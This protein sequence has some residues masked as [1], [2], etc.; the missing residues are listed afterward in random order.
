MAYQRIFHPQIFKLA[1]FSFRKCKIQNLRNITPMESKVHMVYA[2]AT[3]TFPTVRGGGQAKWLPKEKGLTVESTHTQYSNTSKQTPTSGST[4]KQ[5]HQSHLTVLA[6]TTQHNAF[7][8][9]VSNTSIWLQQL[10]TDNTTACSSL[11]HCSH[12]TVSNQL[13]HTPCRHRRLLPSPPFQP[14]WK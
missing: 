6:L 11:H 12:R 14:S 5:Q 10:P 8:C 2:T 7:M 4:H 13:L 9:I 1:V 3:M